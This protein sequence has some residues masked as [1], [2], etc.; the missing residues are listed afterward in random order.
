MKPI[1]LFFV[2]ISQ[3]FFRWRANREIFHRI[4]PQLNQNA[5]HG[6][7]FHSDEELEKLALYAEL[8]AKL[9]LELIERRAERMPKAYGD[10]FR[11]IA[12]R[13]LNAQMKRYLEIAEERVQPKTYNPRF[14]AT[15]A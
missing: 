11:F 8:D 2:K 15:R 1:K 3:M 7:P 12:Y 10:A 9:Q 13:D 14:V 5:E 4:F 6:Y